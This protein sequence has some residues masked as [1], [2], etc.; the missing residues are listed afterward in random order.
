MTSGPGGPT[1]LGGMCL[2]E[3]VTYEITG[4]ARPVINCHCSRCRRHT[5]HFMAAT[6]AATE[7]VV[8][9][10]DTLIWYDATDQVQYGFCGRCGS[11]LFWRTE[12]RP[13][14][15][16]IAAGTLTPPTGLETMAA[17]YADH[18]SDYHV[19]DV[20]I[21]THGEDFPT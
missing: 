19:L 15:I 16:S 2:C 5:G 8:I 4:P 6:A 3:S 21:P 12:R 11:T 1:P 18:G 10:G 7:D 9:H 17:I 13:D 14:L 20:S